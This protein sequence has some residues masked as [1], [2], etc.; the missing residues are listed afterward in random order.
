VNIRFTSS[1]TPEDEN[2]M[3]QSVMKALTSILDVLPIAYSVRIDTSD[4]HVY[5]HSKPNL[6]PPAGPRGVARQDGG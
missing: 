3:A 2:L 1:L 5:S 4:L 6:I